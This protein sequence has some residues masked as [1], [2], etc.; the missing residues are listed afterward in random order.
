M[1]E[2]FALTKRDK[3]RAFFAL[4]R[5]VWA[6]VALSIFIAL[7][8]AYAEPFHS[9][10]Y[11][12]ESTPEKISGTILAYGMIFTPFIVAYAYFR[13]KDRMGNN[14]K[15]N[16]AAL[17]SISM[18]CKIHFYFYLMGWQQTLML[19][20]FCFA[21]FNLAVFLAP[22]VKK[23]FSRYKKD[24]LFVTV[25]FAF[26][27]AV[28]QLLNF[29]A[30]DSTFLY[31]VSFLGAVLVFLDVQD[32]WFKLD[33]IPNQWNFDRLYFHTLLNVIAGFWMIHLCYDLNK[34]LVKLLFSI[35][36]YQR[37]EN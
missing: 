35:F 26:V 28:C 32:W 31:S 7:I 14:A 25:I 24:W 20:G 8:I 33:E 17:L 12:P 15:M 16:I 37:S 21:V 22:L 3:G 2:N 13:H 10:F 18:G 29:K 11:M 19:I 34:V 6:F 27:M 36:K 5:T 9:W 4:C 1:E 30:L 23:N